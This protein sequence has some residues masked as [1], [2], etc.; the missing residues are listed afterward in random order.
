MSI[1]TLK[2][3]TKATY[4][5]LSGKDPNAVMVVRGPGQKIPLS[6]G[7]GFSLNG[8]HR[9]IGRVSRQMVKHDWVRHLSPQYAKAR[10]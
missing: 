8:K 2:R 7:G 6:S 4:K 10:L 9:N 3:K 5:C 1:V